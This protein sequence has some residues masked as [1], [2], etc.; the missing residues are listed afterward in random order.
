[1]PAFTVSVLLPPA[2]TEVGLTDALAPAGTPETERFTVCADPDV[3]AVEMVLVPELPW[4]RLSD[5][6]D[7]AI[8]K[9]SVTGA[10]MVKVTEVVCV[11]DAPVPVTVSA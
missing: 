8:E 5:A 4:T 7:A 3:T 11:A 2:V 10:V 6:G 1:V 9:S